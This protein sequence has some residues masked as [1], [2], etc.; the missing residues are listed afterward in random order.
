MYLCMKE[1]TK[2]LSS[3]L[4]EFVKEKLPNGSQIKISVLAS[5]LFC[6]LD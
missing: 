4:L 5:Y 3:I 1:P 6:K 2:E